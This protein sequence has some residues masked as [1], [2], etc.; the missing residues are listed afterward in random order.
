VKLA[1]TTPVER[2]VHPIE[3]GLQ[4]ANNSEQAICIDLQLDPVRTNVARQ[5]FFGHQ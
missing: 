2:L 4:G 3:F 1:G 5:N